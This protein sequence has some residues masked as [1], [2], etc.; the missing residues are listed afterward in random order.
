M[1]DP[2]PPQSRRKF[3]GSLAAGA[4]AAG[5]TPHVL[6]ARD[7]RDVHII[8]GR[9]RFSTNDQVN[10]AVIGAGGMGTV[11]QAEHRIMDRP[12]ALKVINRELTNDPE[13]VQRFRQEVRAAAQCWWSGDVLDWRC[14][15]KVSPT[16]K[17]G[18]C[19]GGG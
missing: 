16:V 1:T 13:V 9:R 19:R 12:V 18:E 2:R 8:P 3:L 6:S 14:L 5:A 4:V 15:T 11:F 10:L 17:D 7:L